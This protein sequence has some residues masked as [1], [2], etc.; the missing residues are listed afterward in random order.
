MAKRRRPRGA[1]NIGWIEEYCRIP[2]GPD[3]GKPVKLRKWQ[4]DEIRKIYDNPH[5]T[6]R[7]IIS[8][9]RKNAKSTLAAFLLLLHLVGPECRRNSQLFSSAKSREQAGLIFNLASK[10]IRMSPALRSTVLVRDARKELFCPELGTLYRAL[11]AEASTAYGLSPVFI[12]H[13]ELGQIRGGQNELYEAL[14]TAT[15]A[16][17][18]PLS[19]IISTQAPGDNDLLSLLI[20]DASQEHDPRVTLSLYTAPLG[21]DPF[22][23]AT[24]R[25]ANPAFDDFLHKREVMAMARDAAR[26]PSREAEYRNLVLN[27]RIESANPFISKTAWQ[28]CGAP[29]VPVS[30]WGNRPVWGGLD[31]SSVNDLSALVLICEIDGVWNVAPTFWLPEEGISERSRLDHAHYDIW[32]RHGELELTPGKSIEYEWVAIRLRELFEAVNIEGVAFDRWGFAHLTPWLRKAGFADE[33]IEKMFIPFGQGYQSMTPAL[34][35][36]EALLLNHKIAHGNHPVLSMCAGRAV[37]HSDPAG[38]RKLDKAKSRGRID[39]MVALAMAVGES[40]K[41]KEAQE[42]QLFFIG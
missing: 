26:M 25:K 19:V 28:A 8:F 3:V 6:R 38:N 4:K 41:K 37:V 22:A 5:G 23:E 13:D 42:P 27:Q 30:Q 36:M 12:V 31:L 9:G 14:E 11:S 2:E 16:Q 39:G 29:I 21:D 40:E 18:N 35:A 24:I 17:D 33:Q 15:G 7:A 20:D 32:A 34:R 10:V 1:R